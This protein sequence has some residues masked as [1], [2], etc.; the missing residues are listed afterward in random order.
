LVH[1]RWNIS[2][3]GKKLIKIFD[4]GIV[5]ATTTL[6]RMKAKRSY[7]T[8]IY[9]KPAPDEY[10]LMDIIRQERLVRN[11]CVAAALDQIGVPKPR[12]RSNLS[13][14]LSM[15]QGCLSPVRLTTKPTMAMK[16]SD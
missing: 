3:I 13:Q 8:D 1:Q 10:I 12:K 14:R 4:V 9:G 5:Q 7:I 16:K 15:R 11:V 6:A 2:T